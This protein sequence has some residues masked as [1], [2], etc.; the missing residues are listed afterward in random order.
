MRISRL[1]LLNFRPYAGAELEL[2]GGVN[3]LVGPNG[4][5]KT[6]VLEAIATLALTRPPR[7]GAISELVRWGDTEMGAAAQTELDELELRVRRH[8]GSTRFTRS[9]RLNGNPIRPLDFLGRLR[10]VS[11]WPEDLLLVKSGPE[12]RRR[13]LDVAISQLRPGYAITLGRFRRALEH[14]N[15]LLR[16]I[17]EGGAGIGEL[18][19]W[20]EALVT[21]SAEI[22]R[23]RAAYLVQVGPLATAAAEE[24][25]EHH[26][27][28]VRYRPGL[29]SENEAD[30]E[31][32]L[33]S[34]LDRSLHEEVA[35]AQT[36]YGPHRDDV[37]ILLGGRP[38]RQFASQGQQRT[39]VLALK[40]SEV[41]QHVT[42][43]GSSP[44]LL[45]DD[46]LSELDARHRHGLLATLNRQLL[47]E[48]VLVT[49]TEAQG[50][51]ELLEP[52]QV[53]EVP[54]GITRLEG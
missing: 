20:T 15:A 6:S 9:L 10:V 33:R 36:G 37:E 27:L 41:R 13:M 26:E 30:W 47:V 39:A 3:L 19:P 25:G 7:G 53:L 21:T 40:V 54:S 5:G 43:G 22:M 50:M 23:D 28:K 8:P 11:F 12:P 4:S 51:E 34:D 24:I 46:V 42:L 18:A 31:Q 17:R 38:A 2:R 44:V 1:R 35:R 45:L 14:R 48:Q 52:T 49:S 16:N 29:S 32:A